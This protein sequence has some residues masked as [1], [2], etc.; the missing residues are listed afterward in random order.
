M[1]ELE[2]VNDRLKRIMGMLSHVEEDVFMSAYEGN[3]TAEECAALSKIQDAL[4]DC[5]S[6]IYDVQSELFPDSY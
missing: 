5:M 6:K 1:N 3:Y 4:N 2:W